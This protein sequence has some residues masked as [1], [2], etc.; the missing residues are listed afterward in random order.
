MEAPLSFDDLIVHL[1]RNIGLG[2]ASARRVVDEIL[3]Y[4]SETPEQYILRRHGQLQSESQRNDEIFEQIAAE[5]RRRRF[6]APPLSRRQIRR[7]IYG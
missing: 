4:F 2:P 6:A 5:L 7:L 3:A 1:E